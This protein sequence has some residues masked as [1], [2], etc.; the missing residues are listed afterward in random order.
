MARSNKNLNEILDELSKTNNVNIVAVV[1]RDGF[2]IDSAGS[3]NIDMD[4]LGAMVATSIGTSESL[5]GEFALGE[6]SQ[7][8][9]EYS[10]GKI[11]MATVGNDILAVITDTD[12][13]IGAIRYAIK[14]IIGEVE[15]AL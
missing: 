15:K 11:I 4:G 1:G 6:L 10:S 8:L 13:V 5:G 2:V 14:K 12:A 7:Y 9:V 3:T